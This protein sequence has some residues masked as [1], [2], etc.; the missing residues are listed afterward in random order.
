MQYSKI[1]LIYIN[2]NLIEYLPILISQVTIQNPKFYNSLN[3]WMVDVIKKLY[4]SKLNNN[5]V[6]H[7]AYYEA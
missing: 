2:T 7:K 1:N 4:L 5:N 6:L 3:Q